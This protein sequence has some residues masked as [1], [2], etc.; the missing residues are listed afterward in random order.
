[1][2]LLLLIPA[3]F[4]IFFFIGFATKAKYYAKEESNPA[5]AVRKLLEYSIGLAFIWTIPVAGITLAI[6]AFK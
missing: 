6:L 4:L 2:K 1:M 3:A 5:N